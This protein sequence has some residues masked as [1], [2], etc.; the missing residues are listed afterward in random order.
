MLVDVGAGACVMAPIHGA[1]GLNERGH[2]RE[3][4]GAAP[5]RRVRSRARISL[6]AA[7]AARPPRCRRCPNRL[8]R[9]Q[10]CRRAPELPPLP[11]VVVPPAPPLPP[12]Y[13]W[14]SCRC[15]SWSSRSRST[16]SPLSSCEPVVEPVPV[17]EPV[18]LVEPVPVEEPVPLLVEPVPVPVSRSPSSRRCRGP[19]RSVALSSPEQ[20]AN[21]AKPTAMT[22]TAKRLTTLSIIGSN[23]SI[24]P[25]S[26]RHAGFTPKECH[27]VRACRR[28]AADF[29]RSC[30]LTANIRL[31]RPVHSLPR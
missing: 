20:L 2:L 21:T 8:R 25:A 9:A 22:P 4:C 27:F 11:P 14:C 18:P 5:R 7:G 30:C 1:V 12:G 31:G 15:P 6:S 23:P 16:R 19:S 26:R 3:G 24:Q 17:D 10:S 29:S 28:N 13:R